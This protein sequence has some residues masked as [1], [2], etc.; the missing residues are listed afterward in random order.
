LELK[1]AAAVGT[2]L[3]AGLTGCGRDQPDTAPAV[4]VNAGDQTVELRPTQ[5][6]LGDSGQRY[7]T[8][9]PIIEVSPDS[10][11]TFTVPDAVARQGWGVQVFDQKLEEK[12]GEVHV[13]KGAA[14]FRGINASDV[15]PPA[16]YLVVVENKG[17][18]CGGFSG[19]WPVGF[20]RAD[21]AVGTT[22]TSPSPS[23]APAG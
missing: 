14:V 16:F 3:L 11:V 17:S 23:S 1:H 15:V 12:I 22:S 7:D 5:Y 9:P 21:G 13:D 20:I 4:T 2:L 10:T 18:A 6:C 8:V 19:A